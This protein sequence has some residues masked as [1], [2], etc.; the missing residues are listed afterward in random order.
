MP[1]Q[2][3]NII[4]LREYDF[5][6][7]VKNNTSEIIVIRA[8]DVSFGEEA[9]VCVR[10]HS[11]TVHAGH[12]IKVIARPISITDEEPEVD[13]IGGDVAT[14]TIDNDTNDGEMLIAALTP[15]FGVTVQVVVQGIM[16]NSQETLKAKISVDLVER[17]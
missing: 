9:D 16:G 5:T 2:V 8:L 4:T 14:A 7:L 6:E 3:R 1:A 11:A 10:V 13:Y 12:S 17:D 15:P